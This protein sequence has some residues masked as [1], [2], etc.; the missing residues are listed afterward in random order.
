MDLLPVFFIDTKE[1]A[2]A[3]RG[4]EGTGN[5]DNLIIVKNIWIHTFG[6][7]FQSQL[8]NVVVN[9]TGFVVNAISNAEYQ[10]G[11]NGCFAIFTKACEA[12]A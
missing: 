10:F 1:A 4:F 9:I 5:S 8:F 12:I 3:H 6:S 2:A 7:T 11:K